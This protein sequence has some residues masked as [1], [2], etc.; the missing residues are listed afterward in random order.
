VNEVGVDVNRCLEH[1]HT[2]SALQ[3]V[4]GLG[5]RKAAYLLKILR[6][7]DNLLE[8]RTKLVTVCQ[9][10][11]KVFMNCAGFIK[12]DTSRVAEKTDAYV[13]VLDGTRVHPET[14][15]WARKM[16]VDALEYDDTTEDANPTSALEE[17][18][19]SPEKLRDLDLDAFAE[20][21]KRQGF[22]DKNITLYDI[23]AELT[24]RY[25]DMRS[26]YESPDNTTLF[27]MLTKETDYGLKQGK[28]VIGR[29]TGIVYK[30]PKN[31]DEVMEPKRDAKTGMWQ[32]SV[33]SSNTFAELSDVWQHFDQNQCP[34]A[35]IG[36]RV[37]L[38]NGVS[39]FIPNRNL[40]DKPVEHPANRVQVGMPIYCRIMSFD[41][42]RFSVNLSCTSSI[43]RD[44]S[45]QFKPALDDYFDRDAERLDAK[46][47]KNCVEKKQKQQYV[48]RVIAH[49]CF[50]NCSYKE[51]ESF[52]ESRD[53]GEVV[54]RPSSKGENHLTVTW[55]VT[56]GIY[57]H[58]DVIESHK[59][60]A[61]SLGRTLQI[62]EET[63]EDLDE[64]IARHIEPMASYAREIINYKY[65][66][67]LDD[68][69][70]RREEVE[71]ILFDEKRKNPSRISYTFTASRELPG[72]FMLSYLP[73]NKTRHEFVTVVPNGLRFRLIV[74]RNLNSL[75]TWF[76]QHFRDPIPGATPVTATPMD[77]ASS[78]RLYDV[79]ELKWNWH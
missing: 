20:E 41:A 76:K 71:R 9:M 38:E 70:K 42:N 34:G 67:A 7:S 4:C 73:R 10:G 36:V 79:R 6:Q 23:R 49:P 26:S 19:E 43:L 78:A 3:F 27:R 56:D 58:I 37:K 74:H 72:K 66:H 18:L 61:F 14:Y 44:A 33:C 1:P 69:F 75:L 35:A 54:I 32:C 53:Q 62:G 21:L 52:L 68:S 51:A 12:I 55:K 11:P 2:S 39:G 22:G 63:F 16:A 47:E 31:D 24:N 57:Q 50:Q 48:K 59:D 17:I 8:N 77:Q 28:L 45:G 15:E 60:N 5:P 40:S 65:Y 46:K 13:E 29:V 25:K 30:K 64:I